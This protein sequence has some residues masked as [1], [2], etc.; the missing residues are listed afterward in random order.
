MTGD[1]S[2]LA[3]MKQ[4]EV[5]TLPAFWRTIPRLTQWTP[6]LTCLHP[7][8]SHPHWCLTIGSGKEVL[9]FPHGQSLAEELWSDVKVRPLSLRGA[10]KTDQV[11]MFLTGGLEF[12]PKLLCKV[13]MVRCERQKPASEA[14]FELDLDTPCTFLLA[15]LDSIA[16][17]TWYV[18]LSCPQTNISQ[19]NC[20]Q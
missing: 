15:P 18:F 20:Y 11:E 2:Q 3:V 13:K 14:L 1:P 4:S 16:F 6:N 12:I 5:L 7:S 9:V 19:F 10:W 17:L 8:P